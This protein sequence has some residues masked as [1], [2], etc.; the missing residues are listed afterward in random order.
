M[1]RSKIGIFLDYAIR[2]PNFQQSYSSF[3]EFLFKDIYGV[4]FQDKIMENDPR[5]YWQTQLENTEIANFY[6]SKIT[7]KIDDIKIRGDFSSYFYN[8]DHEGK[9]LFKFGMMPEW[10]MG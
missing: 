8:K 6:M 2:I 10:L 4:E 5:F 7:D 3:K 1:K 9:F